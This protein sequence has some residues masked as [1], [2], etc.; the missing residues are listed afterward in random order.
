MV[1]EKIVSATKRFLI[2]ARKCQLQYQSQ[3][4][5]LYL[6]TYIQNILEE[7]GFSDTNLTNGATFTTALINR[8]NF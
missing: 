6:V 1:V 8:A 5:G 2:T 4:I 7:E 3:N